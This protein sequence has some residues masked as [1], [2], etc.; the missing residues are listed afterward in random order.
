VFVGFEAG[1][2]KIIPP[3]GAPAVYQGGKADN[4]NLGRKL[5]GFFAPPS[6]HFSTANQLV[7]IPHVPFTPP[8]TSR[9]LSHANRKLWIFK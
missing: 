3:T 2:N 5:K 8:V 9:C 4:S 1:C 6:T 7:Y